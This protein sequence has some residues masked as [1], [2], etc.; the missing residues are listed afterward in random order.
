MRQDHCLDEEMEQ[1]EQRRRYLV[2]GEQDETARPFRYPPQML[3]ENTEHRRKYNAMFDAAKE[4][5]TFAATPSFTKMISS[6]AQWVDTHV[7]AHDTGEIA[8]NGWRVAPD[9][10]TR[11]GPASSTAT[12]G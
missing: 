6:S 9:S 11:T 8:N 1:L 2:I 4:A 10:S 12:S 5:Y 3:V 7:P